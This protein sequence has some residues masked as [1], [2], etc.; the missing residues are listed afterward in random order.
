MNRWIGMGRITKDLEL[1]YTPSNNTAVC[2]FQLAVDRRFKKEG[3]PS[4]DFLSFVA[5][6]KTAEFINKWMKKGNQICIV[7]SV[8]TRNYEKEGKKIYITEIV[9]DEVYF[10][11]GK[12]SDETQGQV[13]AETAK[14]FTPET[15]RTIN[16][17][18]GFYPIDS[19]QLPF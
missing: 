7:G 6:Q 17:E 9:V 11:E 13:Q 16:G 4:C 15:Q 5:W 12:K 10:A 19:D 8:Q 1:K 18:L 14:G 2:S 3:S